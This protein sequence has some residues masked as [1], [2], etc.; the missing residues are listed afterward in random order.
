MAKLKVFLEKNE[1]IE[2]AKEL[3]KKALNGPHSH[4][5]EDYE[6]LAMEELFNTITREYEVMHEN[7]VREINEA[8]DS[9]FEDGSLI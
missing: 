2:D 8:L 7:M 1:T 5:S 6:D 9:E 3:I 4:E